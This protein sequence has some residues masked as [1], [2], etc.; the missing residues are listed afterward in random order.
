VLSLVN[1]DNDETFQTYSSFTTN[2]K[3]ADQYEA[4]LV[5]ASKGRSQALK[6]YSR[7]QGLEQS[8]VCIQYCSSMGTKM[9]DRY[10]QDSL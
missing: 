1:L 3:T 7:R 6:A 2:H 10:K 8:L 9:V 5:Q 4:L